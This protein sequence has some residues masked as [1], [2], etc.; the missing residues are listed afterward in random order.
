MLGIEELEELM[1]EITT[2]ICNANRAGNL[3]S[4]LESMGLANLLK[5]DKPEFESYKD[6]KIV[7]IG[8][9]E[10]KKDVLKSIAKS[11]GIDKNRLEFCLDYQETKSY[12]YRKLQYSPDYRVV[13]FGPVPHKTEGTGESSSIIVELEKNEAYP[14]VERLMA[15]GKLKITKTSFRQA[16][17]ELIEEGYIE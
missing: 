8:Q 1:G 17:E 10:V 6:G 13:L 15:G 7:V 4:L 14:R 3:D 2:L 12:N 5:A 9:T 11:I 16:L